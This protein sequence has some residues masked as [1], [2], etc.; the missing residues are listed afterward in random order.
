MCLPPWVA[1]AFA[2]QDRARAAVRGAEH[3]AIRDT[4]IDQIDRKEETVDEL[5]LGELIRRAV[6]ES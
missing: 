4:T 3:P 5:F 1:R 6:S 2:E